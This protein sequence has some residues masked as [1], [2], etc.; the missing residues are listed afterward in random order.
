MSGEARE[1]E[2]KRLLL[3][4]KHAPAPVWSDLP[5]DILCVIFGFLPVKALCTVARCCKS[6]KSISERSNIWKDLCSHHFGRNDGLCNFAGSWKQF[7]SSIAMN[8]KIFTGYLFIVACNTPVEERRLTAVIGAHGGA[9]LPF[10]LR[11]GASLM[12]FPASTTS[13]SSS[14]EESEVTPTSENASLCLVDL[15]ATPEVVALGLSTPPEAVNL[16]VTSVQLNLNPT[17]ACIL[18]LDATSERLRLA[19][20]SDHM[21]RGTLPPEAVSNTGTGTTS[22]LD[23]DSTTV[24]S[25]EDFGG[26]SVSVGVSNARGTMRR[27]STKRKVDPRP[28]RARAFYNRI[29]SKIAKRSPHST[30]S[31]YRNPWGPGG[32][33]HVVVSSWDVIWKRHRITP[34]PI[35]SPNQ[36]NLNPDTSRPPGLISTCTDLPPMGG[37]FPG[38]VTPAWVDLCVS[39]G[40]VAPI[41]RADV[42][43]TP[44]PAT[45]LPGFESDLFCVSGYEGTARL[46]V[47]H[48]L[49]MLGARYEPHLYRRYTTTLIANRKDTR[50]CVK[51]HSWSI[52]VVNTEWLAE[53]LRRWSRVDPVPYFL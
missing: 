4:R 40:R 18:G 26:M 32:L 28:P 50:K 35:I 31:S 46:R 16:G 8:A 33:T 20:S 44:A 41:A 1:K 29:M 43:H 39:A 3:F 15:N 12:N 30:F 25:E 38:V 42:L 27:T 23:L 5:D 7:Y 48:M 11:A 36:T 19:T 9:V 13:S 52:P 49:S 17:S 2:L 22:V 47:L 10:C 53:C 45:R 37:P 34:D 6:W 14:E 21:N 51:A 24:A